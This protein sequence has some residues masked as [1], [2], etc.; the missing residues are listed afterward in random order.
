ML[1]LTWLPDVDGDAD[2]HLASWRWYEIWHSIGFLTLIW[3]CW[4]LISFLTLIWRCWHSLGFL[5]LMAMLLLQSVVVLCLPYPGGGESLGVAILSSRISRRTRLLL[6]GQSSWR[7]EFLCQVYMWQ[8]RIFIF[9]IYLAHIVYDD[10][11]LANIIIKI[12]GLWQLITESLIFNLNI[13]YW[14]EWINTVGHVFST[15]PHHVCC[16]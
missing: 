8:G 11:Q 6:P 14:F 15:S 1:T 5:T 16:R 9:R 3:R 2:T 10:N 13:L 4:H 7:R 12:R